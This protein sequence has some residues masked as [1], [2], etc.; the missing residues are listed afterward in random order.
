MLNLLLASMFTLRHIYLTD[1][2]NTLLLSTNRSRRLKFIKPLTKNLHMS[3]QPQW[4][5]SFDTVDFSGLTD[6]IVAC[7]ASD[8]KLDKFLDKTDKHERRTIDAMTPQETRHLLEDFVQHHPDA[9]RQV[10]RLILQYLGINKSVFLPPRSSSIT[11]DS[12]T[13]STL[14]DLTQSIPLLYGEDDIM[15]NMSPVSWLSE[16]SWSSMS[17]EE[18]LGFMEHLLNGRFR[19]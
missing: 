4:K 10:A 16:D 12:D 3:L 9:E 17:Y 14:I 18:K 6:K 13:Y 5:Y 2:F 15:P 1:S 11:N 7:I 19:R 8:L